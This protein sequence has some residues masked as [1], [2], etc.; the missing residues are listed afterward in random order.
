VTLVHRGRVP[1]VTGA[2]LFSRSR[3]LDHRRDGGPAGLL[4]LLSAKYTT[5][6]ATAETAV[7]AAVGRLSGRPAPCRTAMTPLRRAA[8]LEGTLAE[9][10]RAA[11]REE[12]ALHLDDCLLRRLD[13]AT[14]GRPAPAAV[15]EVAAVMAQELGWDAARAARERVRLEEALCATEA[16]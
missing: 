4:S 16:R 11:V 8:P 1:G 12:A 10:T 15:D 13:L 5:A 14:A 7:D 6:R 9:Q 2:A 3:V